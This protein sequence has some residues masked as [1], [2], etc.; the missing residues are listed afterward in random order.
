MTDADFI[1][2]RTCPFDPPEALAGLREREPISTVHMWD[3]RPAWLVTRYDDAYALLRDR[4]ISADSTN[5]GF[6]SLSP[7]RTVPIVRRS[8]SRMDDPKHAELRQMVAPEFSAVQ[9]ERLRPDIQRLVDRQVDHLLGT[10]R[11]ADLVSE[12]AQPISTTVLS[13]LIGIPR[14]TMAFFLGHA[15]TVISR[16]KVSRQTATAET[17]M[18]G[19]LHALVTEQEREPGD[20]LI[21]RL[22]VNELRRGTLSHDELVR[23]VHLLI[24]AGFEN[25]A[26]MMGLGVLSMLMDPSWFDAVSTQPE[27]LADLVEELLRYHSIANHDGLPRV[28]AEDMTLRDVTIRAGDS[29]IV[30]LASANRDEEVFPKA[31]ELDLSRDPRRHLAFGQGVHMCP[32]R[33][34]ARAELQI[35]LSTV[36]GRIPTLRLAAP[37]EQIPFR[38]DMHSYGVYALPVTW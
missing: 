8:F 30:S 38:E 17:A 20:T 9:V 32:G 2:P 29:V 34:L 35:A 21:G 27:R 22:V 16:T 25:P 10:E 11:P 7:G 14:D 31:A 4:R 26:N 6:P 3:G 23:I 24:I 37:V 19:V 18:H 1:P 12:F 28:A 13:G 15:E 36:A 5:P 33:W